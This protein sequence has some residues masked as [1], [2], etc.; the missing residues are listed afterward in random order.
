MKKGC[1]D[2]IVQSFPH[3]CPYCDQSVSY[4]PFDLKGGENSIQ[5]PSCKKKFIKVVSDLTDEEETV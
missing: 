2:Q 4:D 1:D 3:G 5:C